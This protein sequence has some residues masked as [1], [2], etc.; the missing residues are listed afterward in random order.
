MALPIVYPHAPAS[1]TASARSMLAMDPATITGPLDR[2]T[3]SRI[4]V[5]RVGGRMA[6]RQQVEAADVIEPGESFCVGRDLVDRAEQDTRVV[7]DPA[8]ERAIAHPVRKDPRAHP[9]HGCRRAPSRPRPRPPSATTP[10]RPPWWSK[11]LRASPRIRRHG[12]AMS[13]H[14]VGQVCTDVLEPDVAQ[15]ACRPASARSRPRCRRFGR[16]G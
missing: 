1:L 13:A 2:R 11:R 9:Q 4:R 14:V 3:T 5:E 7:D 16:R 10:A 8:G 15:P 6:I 12:P